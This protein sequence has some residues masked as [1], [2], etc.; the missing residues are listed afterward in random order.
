MALKLN[1]RRI[2][3]QTVTFTPLETGE[4]GSFIAV[5][6]ILTAEQQS[7]LFEVIQSLNGEKSKDNTHAW[8]Q[9]Q[10][11][12]DTILVDV[13]QLEIEDEQ[14]DLLTGEALLEV[15]KSYPDLA[16]AI[17]AAYFGSSEA[18]KK[19]QKKKTSKKP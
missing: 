11:I 5:F 7:K 16:D 8:G 2:F 15:V 12:L 4:Q 3:K 14:G 1:K 10:K 17:V 19:P 13:E 6:N 18:G 9:I